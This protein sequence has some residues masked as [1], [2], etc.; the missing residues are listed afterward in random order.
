ML[1]CLLPTMATGAVMWSEKHFLEP[2]QHTLDF[3]HPPLLCRSHIEHCWRCSKKALQMFCITTKCDIDSKKVL[4]L[5]KTNEY[6]QM[7]DITKNMTKIGVIIRRVYICL[8][9]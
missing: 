2:N 6:Q 4:F 9:S 8:S 5:T 7:C 3:L 1:L